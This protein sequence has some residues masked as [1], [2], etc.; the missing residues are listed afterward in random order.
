[1]DISR[2]HTDFIVGLSEG[3]VG[4]KSALK[5]LLHRV[6]LDGMQGGVMFVTGK[7]GSG[8]SAVMC[9]L[10]QQ[11]IAWMGIKHVISHI[12]GAA[13]GST[14]IVNI[15]IRLYAEISRRF[16]SIECEIPQD[17]QELVGGLPELLR[18][19]SKM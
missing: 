9:Q 18:R 5:D 11:L 4:R 1:M 17:Y 14:N 15:L 7:P 12:C 19:V 2:E 10:S 8:K 16:P 13:P 3:F 6:S